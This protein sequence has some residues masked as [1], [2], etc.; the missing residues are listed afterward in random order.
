MLIHGAKPRSDPE[1]I[2][3]RLGQ[4]AE[5]FGLLQEVLHNLDGTSPGN[6]FG[7]R[8]MAIAATHLDTSYLW[9]KEAVDQS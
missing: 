2:K 1:T 6:P 5:A 9:A 7:G 8:E 3:K 4:L